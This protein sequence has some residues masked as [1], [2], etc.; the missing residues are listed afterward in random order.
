MTF[1]VVSRGRWVVASDIQCGGNHNDIEPC[2]EDGKVEC[3][4]RSFS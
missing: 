1:G 4:F 3:R 2:K